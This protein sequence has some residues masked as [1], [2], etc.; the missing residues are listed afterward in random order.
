MVWGG[1]FD[2]DNN[3]YIGASGTMSPFF[4]FLHE[5]FGV[6]SHSPMLNVLID[7]RRYMSIQDRDRIISAGQYGSI[8]RGKLTTASDN[9]LYNLCVKKLYSLRQSHTKIAI[10][11]IKRADESYI[12]TEMTTKIDNY[13]KTSNEFRQLN[14]DTRK[15][16]SQ[17]K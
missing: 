6:S 17:T 13:K 16:Y 10:K 7:S 14:Q 4:N 8:I 9:E 2:D 11:T 12:S 15:K 5:F 3:T 1:Y